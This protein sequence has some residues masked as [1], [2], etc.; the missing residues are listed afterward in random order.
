[1]NYFLA[2]GIVLVGFIVVCLAIMF[3]GLIAKLV[4][5]ENRHLPPILFLLVALVVLIAQLI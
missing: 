3:V 2:I 1:M 5:Y 4:S